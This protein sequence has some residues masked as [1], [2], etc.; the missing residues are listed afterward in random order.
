MTYGRKK[1]SLPGPK[2]HSKPCHCAPKY[3]SILGTLRLPNNKK[4]FI[5][6]HQHVVS[7]GHW[8]ALGWDK[9]K[10]RACFTVQETLGYLATRNAY[11]LA[12]CLVGPG[13]DGLH[14]SEERANTKGRLDMDAAANFS[15]F[16]VSP[17]SRVGFVRYPVVLPICTETHHRLPGRW[18]KTF[19]LMKLESYLSIPYVK[20]LGDGY[21]ALF[22]FVFLEKR[23]NLWCSFPCRGPKCRS[24]THCCQRRSLPTNN[25]A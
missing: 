25:F 15:T 7:K 1:T 5:L 23:T 4:L 2:P 16:H 11:A 21:L 6:H 17:Q 13:I 18:N 8:S 10:A 24:R 12:T 19:K 20:C 14:R 3:G 9:R 22:T